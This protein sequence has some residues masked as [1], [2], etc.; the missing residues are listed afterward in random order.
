ML[1][2]ESQVRYQILIPYDVS[3]LTLLYMCRFCLLR[4]TSWS[5]VEL[6]SAVIFTHVTFCVND[7]YYLLLAIASLS[8]SPEQGRPRCLLAHLYS[9][10]E[11]KYRI[12]SI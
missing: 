3:R 2:H 5:C 9:I 6:V 4:N 8:L 10:S 1:Y 12:M 11:I 7:T